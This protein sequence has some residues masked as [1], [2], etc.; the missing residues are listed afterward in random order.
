MNEDEGFVLKPEMYS[1][2]EWYEM[3]MQLLK[4]YHREVDIINQLE[5]YLKKLKKGWK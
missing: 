1:Q 5:K 2:K 4:E 3:Y